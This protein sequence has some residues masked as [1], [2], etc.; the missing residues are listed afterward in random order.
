[1]CEIT[2]YILYLWGVKDLWNL[3]NANWVIY[4]GDDC[5]KTGDGVSG[6]YGE[7]EVNALNKNWE[8]TIADLIL[9]TGLD[10]RGVEKHFFLEGDAKPIIFRSSFDDPEDGKVTFS[11]IY[12]GNVKD[13]KTINIYD[14][15]TE[16][17]YRAGSIYYFTDWLS[18]DYGSIKKP[19]KL[20]LTNSGYNYNTHWYNLLWYYTVY[21]DR[22]QA[23]IM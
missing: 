2:D 19:V 9:I 17:I 8:F 20:K 6:G 4:G 5:L 15:F 12:D 23:F 3:N 18:F 22:D 10:P 16:T 1:M 11:I 13:S 21:I 7:R 14:Y